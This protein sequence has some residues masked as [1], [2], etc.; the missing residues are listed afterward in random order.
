MSIGLAAAAFTGQNIGANQID[1]VKQGVYSSV[2]LVAIFSLFMF[3]IIFFGGKWIMLLFANKDDYEVIQIGANALR[4][5]CFFYFF[6]GVIGIT[7]SFLGGAGD[8][9]TPLIMGVME[10]ISRV[11]VANVFVIYIGFYG[12][13]WATAAAWVLTASV[14]IIS[15]FIGRW[16]TKSI[17]SPA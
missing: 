9:I 14:G 10:V 6:V 13:W 1:R 15:Y 11:V 8:V 17:V 7:R 2:I 12:I 4:I 5:T 3:P 16:K